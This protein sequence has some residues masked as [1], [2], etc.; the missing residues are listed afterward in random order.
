MA[1][2][3]EIDWQ[4]ALVR[5][6]AHAPF[7]ARA[8]DRQPALEELLSAGEGDRALEWSRDIGA[9]EDTGIGLRRHRLALAT[10]LA[11]G[12]LAGA[13]PLNR[14]VTELSEFADYAL[15]KAIRTAIFERASEDCSDGMIA[16]AL[17]KQGACELNY[18][19]DIDPILLYDP[20]RLR[21]RAKDEPAEAA[22]RYARRV[23]TLLSEN[24]GEGYVARVDLRLRPASE[25]SPPAVP[26]KSAITH[27][28]GQALAWER[29]A[30]VRARAAA[31]D[32]AAKRTEQF[33][34]EMLRQR[35]CLRQLPLLLHK[36]HA[37][38]PGLAL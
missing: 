13:F 10:S 12:D 18:S 25:I 15:D 5:A 21:H 31:G 20:A 19:S 6:R 35:Q 23:V 3:G 38:R 34:Q 8:L 4:G 11:I 30:Y 32:I 17:G 9:H 33:Q 27:Y 29:A 36:R 2:T 1:Q 7:L 22:Q 26:V 28:Q 37:P 14:V 24:T 16:L